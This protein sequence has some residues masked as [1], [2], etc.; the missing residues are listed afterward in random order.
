M[1]FWWSFELY[2]TIMEVEEEVR[3]GNIIQ[4]PQRPERLCGEG[5]C[6][7]KPSGKNG[8]CDI[9]SIEKETIC[10]HLDCKREIYHNYLCWIHGGRR[11]CI[12]RGCPD[13]ECSKEHM[14][15]KHSKIHKKM[16]SKIQRETNPRPTRSSEVIIESKVEENAKTSHILS[17]KKHKCQHCNIG[18][19]EEW[20]LKIHIKKYCTSLFPTKKKKLYTRTS[21]G[22]YK[23]PQ[24][25]CDFA[26]NDYIPFHLKNHCKKNPIGNIRTQKAKAKPIIL[27]PETY[28]DSDE[29]TDIESEVDGIDDESEDE[30]ERVYSLVLVDDIYFEESAGT[31]LEQ[32]LI[33]E[34]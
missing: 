16:I 4:A 7:K 28:S 10:N 15:A 30:E 22:R 17:K 21:N 24:C 3:P 9:H 12:E 18:Y 19:K 34:K 27:I 26:C 5:S 33:K 6:I 20:Y 32:Q 11:R 14:C 25:E 23:C 31:I 8:L 2:P 29:S 1:S 13:K